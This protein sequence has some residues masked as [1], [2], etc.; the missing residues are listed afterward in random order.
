MPLPAVA[1]Q[2]DW[3]GLRAKL[4]SAKVAGFAMVDRAVVLSPTKEVMKP[5]ERVSGGVYV[6]VI[7]DDGPAIRVRTAVQSAGLAEIDPAYDLEGV[8]PRGALVPV[9]ARPIVKD[10]P[11]G[12]GFVW[13]DGLELAFGDRIAPAKG[14]LA[15]L[16]TD[17][18]P[19]DVTLGFTLALTA[20]TL[21]PASGTLLGCTRGEGGTRVDDP[22]TLRQERV[23][24]WRSQHPG[25]S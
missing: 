12:T 11:D 4:Q 16:A 8:V 23:A 13:R 18:S 25:A 1:K 15:K 7:E 5:R 2:P 19:D 10:N 24:E 21:A 3:S 9:V 14:L 20:P 6:T 22:D 17:L